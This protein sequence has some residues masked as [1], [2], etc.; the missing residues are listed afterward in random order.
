[1]ESNRKCWLKGQGYVVSVRAR[2][3]EYVFVI[4]ATLLFAMTGVFAENIEHSWPQ[5]H[6]PDRDNISR[7]TGLLKTW[8]M[9]GPRRVSKVVRM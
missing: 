8:P 4:V 5:F 6:G 2:V 1:M 3:R 9:E 7:E